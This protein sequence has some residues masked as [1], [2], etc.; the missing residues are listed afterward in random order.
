MY[1]HLLTLSDEASLVW[2]A[3]SSVAKK[4]FLINRYMVLASQLGI[5]YRTPTYLPDSG[6]VCLKCNS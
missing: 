6:L 2:A 4:L 1:D 5:A 3:R